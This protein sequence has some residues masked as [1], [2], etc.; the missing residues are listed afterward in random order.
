MTPE[1]ERLFHQL[2]NLVVEA[3]SAILAG[4][5]IAAADRREVEELLAYDAPGTEGSQLTAQVADAALWTIESGGMLP[6]SRCGRYRLVK[7]LGAGG[8]GAVFLAEGEKGDVAQRV[9]V[10]FLNT[11]FTCGRLEQQLL[12]ERRLVALLAHP[13]IARFID[14]G[15]LES[16]QPYLVMEYVD[17][18]PI[19]R[20]CAEMPWPDVLRIFRKVCEAA[21]YAH[22]N[23]IVHRDLKPGNILVTPDGEPKLID[24]GVGTLLDFEKRLT[25]TATRMLTPAYASPEQLLGNPVGTAADVYGLGATLY[26]LLS[27]RPP[28]ESAASHADMAAREPVPLRKMYCC[29]SSACACVPQTCSASAMHGP[30]PRTESSASA[31]KPCSVGASCSPFARWR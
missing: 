22:A 28:F 1:A 21:A 19:D 27:G 7:L 12:S 29:R 10:K 3:R 14:S 26:H 8:M 17:G 5:Q 4:P 30:P 24:F 25:D 6:G 15:T 18:Q 11:A 20:H 2:A 16:G 31:P 23:L 13:N 9:A